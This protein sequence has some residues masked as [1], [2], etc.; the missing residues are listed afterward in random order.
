M[1]PI[2]RA[3]GC[4]PYST[5]SIDALSV[6]SL[7]L[8]LIELETSSYPATLTTSATSHAWGYLAF[9]MG[10]KRPETTFQSLHIEGDEALHGIMHATEERVKVKAIHN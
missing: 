2:G 9:N 3:A 6:V 1:K 8:E 5:P 4:L 7:P 10:K